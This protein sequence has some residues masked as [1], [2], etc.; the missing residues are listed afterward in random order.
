MRRTAQLGLQRQRCGTTDYANG[1]VARLLHCL[2]QDCRMQLLH[3]RV[4][5]SSSTL[6]LSPTHPP[7][8]GGRGEGDLGHAAA[9]VVV[10]AMRCACGGVWGGVCGGG[11][12]G[13]G[14]TCPIPCRYATSVKSNVCYMKTDKGMSAAPH[15]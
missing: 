8:F 2:H 10:A 12:G 7:L 4:R 5:A 14:L 3:L 9:V 1:R 13:G 11:G 15:D 6:S